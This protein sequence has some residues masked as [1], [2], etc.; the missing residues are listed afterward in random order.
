M[1][2]INIE[3]LFLLNNR[4]IWPRWT[5]I[6]E[7]HRELDRARAV[8]F[9]TDPA[10]PDSFAR[11]TCGHL[12]WLQAHVSS[13]RQVSVGYQEAG[14]RRLCFQSQNCQSGATAQT[15]GCCLLLTVSSVPT[16]A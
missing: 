10:R 11:T 16:R 12:S 6:P 14:W 13:L 3:F 9:A 7:G 1:F 15:S 8:Q 5:H 4:A 2:Q